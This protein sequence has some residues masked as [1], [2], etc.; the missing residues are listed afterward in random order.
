MPVE[1]IK[2]DFDT[3]LL[4]N[5]GPSAALGAND[6]NEL[7]DYDDEIGSDGNIDLGEISAQYLSLELF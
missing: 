6:I 1:I 4:D 2:S 7:L 3:L 5:S